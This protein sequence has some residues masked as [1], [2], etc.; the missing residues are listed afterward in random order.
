MAGYTEPTSALKGTEKGVFGAPPLLTGTFVLEKG[1][2]H[3]VLRKTV[4]QWFSTLLIQPPFNT[5]PHA[6]LT[7]TMTLLHYYYHLLLL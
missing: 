1:N 7:P 6:R 3:L 4:E 5:V 2:A